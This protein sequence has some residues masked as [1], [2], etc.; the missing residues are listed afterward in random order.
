[1][2]I[3]L[4]LPNITESTPDGKLRQLQSY[5]YQTVEQLNWAL[6]TLES[7]G[8]GAVVMQGKNTAGSS[9]GGEDKKD[10]GVDFNELK[11]LIIKSA[12]I[13]NAYYEKISEKLTGKYVAQSEFGTY[14]QFTE[15]LILGNSYNIEQLFSNIQKIITDV[16][17]LEKTLI[18]VNAYI[19]SGELYTDDNGIPIY[20][21]EIGQKTEVDGVEVFN[22]FARFTA[23]KLSFYDYNGREVAYISDNKLYIANIEITG[24]FSQGGFVDTVQPDLSIITRWV[25][26]DGQ[27]Q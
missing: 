8:T 7:G 16:E 26:G 11:A 13:V 9:S 17:G 25:G 22:Q 15:Q 18:D 2:S 21:L 10:N 12:D 14:E 27:W 5:L 3:N 23:E 1:M 19:K 4:R 6:N 24:S 20:G